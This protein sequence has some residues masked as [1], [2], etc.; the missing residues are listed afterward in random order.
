MKK[1]LVGLVALTSLSASAT[2]P[3]MECSKVA[4]QA[5]I[6]VFQVS[7]KQTPKVLQYIASRVTA[8]ELVEEPMGRFSSLQYRVD[9]EYKNSKG[10]KGHF[11]YTVETRKNKD[12]KDKCFVEAVAYNHD[13]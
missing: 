8:E 3:S 5:A 10:E 12:A 6:A 4:K 9:M 2:E 7:A 11:F 1:L 13:D